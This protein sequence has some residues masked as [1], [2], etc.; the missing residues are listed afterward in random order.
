MEKKMEK[1]IYG[2]IVDALENG[3][4]PEGFA[5]SYNDPYFK[6]EQLRMAPG[7]IDGMGIYHVRH[8]E[9]T[10]MDDNEIIDA[11]MAA[12]CGNPQAYAMFSGLGRR[13]RAI[14]IID[15]LQQH[16]REH[17]DE[18]DA[19][20]LYKFA[21][22][23]LILEGRDIECVKFGLVLLELFGEPNDQVKEIVRNLGLYSEFTIFSVFNMLLWENG[24][25]EIFNLAKNVEGWGRVHA[26]E[27]LK[28]ETQEIK[29]W[30]L[31]EGETEFPED[32]M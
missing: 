26:V 28:P 11:I 10:E 13:L 2:E 7:A 8:E 23:N 16:V 15:E 21:I 1:T 17:A 24:N 22:L 18:L 3:R 19:A 9:L 29:D 14:D 32:E 4:L 27:R 20:Q 12:S 25:E 30:L 31:Y 6:S 5:I